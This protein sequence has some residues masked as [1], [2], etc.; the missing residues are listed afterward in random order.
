V[1]FRSGRRT[2]LLP[3]LANLSLP[4]PLALN[5]TSLHS[6]SNSIGHETR[7]AT[8]RATAVNNENASETGSKTSR[9][10][11]KSEG[12][13][14]VLAKSLRVPPNPNMHQSHFQME[15]SNY[16]LSN[17]EVWTD[18]WKAADVLEFSV[19]LHAGFTVNDAAQVEEEFGGL[20]KTHI[21]ESVENLNAF[22]ARID[23]PPLDRKDP[24]TERGFRKARVREL[25]NW[26]EGTISRPL[27]SLGWSNGLMR[28]FFDGARSVA[29]Q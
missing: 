15:F 3:L 24:A 21:P 9:H 19:I 8:K 2:Y 11:F 4:L 25:Q 6:Y 14:L 17:D 26:A 1:S 23:D 10:H 29:L 5:D 18:V 20:S 27:N 12:K 16:M 7:A 22:W 28:G 13:A